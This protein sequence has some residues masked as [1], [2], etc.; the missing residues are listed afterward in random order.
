MWYK[1]S[2]CDPAGMFHVPACRA[3]LITVEGREPDE[4]PYAAILKA[5]IVGATVIPFD[6]V[7]RKWAVIQYEG[8]PIADDNSE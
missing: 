8:I 7:P 2:D 3:D 1:A 5:M 6:T 4:C